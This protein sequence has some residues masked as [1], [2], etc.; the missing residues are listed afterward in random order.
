MQFPDNATPEQRAIAQAQ[1][2][3]SR[4]AGAAMFRMHQENFKNGR[5]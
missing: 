4:A 1:D 3:R 5:K 2:E